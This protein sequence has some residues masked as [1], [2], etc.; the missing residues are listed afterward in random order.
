MNF[1]ALYQLMVIGLKLAGFINWNWHIVL[2][3][4]EVAV[5]AWSLGMA[6]IGYSKVYL[7][8]YYKKH[9]EEKKR[10][11]LIAALKAYGDAVCGG[12]Q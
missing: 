9:P 4:I 12:K 5:S 10:R 8:F 7:Y 11:E 2:I 1:I 6:L 3:P